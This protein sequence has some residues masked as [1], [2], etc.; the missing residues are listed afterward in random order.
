M[1]S[2]RTGPEPEPF[3]NTP[4]IATQISG[5]EYDDHGDAYMCVCIKY[6]YI[7]IL[8]IL[9]FLLLS[10]DKSP[11]SA[12]IFKHGSFPIPRFVDGSEQ[13]LQ[14]IPANLLV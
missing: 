10:S 9:L 6:I 5:G 12:Y 14:I 1:G 3:K 4:P 2:C 8:V 13:P 11:F 7:Y